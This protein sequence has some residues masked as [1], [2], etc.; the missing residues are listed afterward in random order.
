MRYAWI[1]VAIVAIWLLSA[2]VIA[3][4]PQSSPE[5]VFSIAAFGTIVLAFLGFRTPRIS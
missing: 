3:V 5:Y 1:S 2:W 4:R